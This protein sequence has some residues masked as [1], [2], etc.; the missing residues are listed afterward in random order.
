MSDGF[1]SK[2][3]QGAFKPEQVEELL[4]T[5]G[6]MLA[7]LIDAAGEV[8]Q[9]EQIERWLHVTVGPYRIR[10]F[11]SRGGMALVFRAERCDGQFEQTVAIKVLHTSDGA[12]LAKRFELERQMLGKLEHP[13]IAR[14]LDSGVAAG[15]PWLAMEFVDGTHIGAYCDN[16]QLD[17]DARLDLFIQVARA[18]Q[19]AHGRLIVHRDIKPSNILVCTDGIT[20]LLDF[21]IA[22]VLRGDESP[23]LTNAAMLLTPQYASPEQVLGE[24]V[25]VASDI[26]QLGLLL[27]QLLTGS[28]PQNIDNVSVAS[29]KSVVID[30]LPES[31]SERVETTGHH[32]SKRAHELAAARSTSISRLHKMLLG[33]LD[34]IVIKCL[35]K[36]PAE[37]YAT[38]QALSEDIAAFRELRPITARAP[39]TW[40]RS[41]RFVRRHRGGVLSAVLT[42]IVILFALAAVGVS[43]RSTIDAQQ[44]ALEEAAAARQV[45]DFLASMLEEANP[46]RTGGSA[47]TVRELLDEAMEQI[48]ALNDQPR[49]QARLLEV[50]AGAYFELTVFGPAEQ[51]AR[52]AIELREQIGDS[53]DMVEPLTKLALVRMELGDLDEALE[54]GQR[55][56]DLADAMDASPVMRANANDALSIVYFQRGAYAEQREHL[57]LA[58]KQ[59]EVAGADENKVLRAS[60][61]YKLAANSKQEGE[62]AQAMEEAKAALALL[63][64]APNE[65]ATRMFVLRMLG[66]AQSDMGDE[67]LA[68]E[69]LQESVDLA[70][71]IYREEE[72]SAMML[73][74]LVL[75]ARS[76]SNLN[77]ND[78]AEQLF[79]EALSIAESNI[80]RTHGNYAR[81]LHDYAEVLRRRGQF[82]ELREMRA[83][84]VAIAAA[85]FGPEHSTTI[86]LRKAEAYI[87]VGEGRYREALA[88]INEVL[89]QVMNEFGR[90]HMISFTTSENYA[91]ML[92]ETGHVAEARIAMNDLIGDGRAILDGK[93]YSYMINLENLSR[94]HF[95]TGRLDEARRV[96]DEAIALGRQL[97]GSLRS[98]VSEAMLTRTNVLSL[99]A[100]GLAADVVDPLLRTVRNSLLQMPV[101]RQ[102]RLTD[103]A[104]ALARG[105]RRAESAETCRLALGAL[106]NAVSDDI[107]ILAYARLNCAA[108]AMVLG[109]SDEAQKLLAVSLPIVSEALGEENWQ[110]Q[111]AIFMD[112]KLRGD[113][114][115]QNAAG[116]K[117]RDVLGAATPIFDGL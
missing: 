70:R 76:L 31:P 56:T 59:L 82:S 62:Y 17:I 13:G 75:L 81:I 80:G 86:N 77:R 91:R 67:E 6:G 92:L 21:G 64:D 33:D 61:L 27:Y 113:T 93:F 97:V 29:I 37:R 12:E 50:L 87:P 96:A 32:D 79:R 16:R 42:L 39:S 114:A 105:N 35:R 107:P 98:T 104:I 111:W 51:A 25:G 69:T 66:S 30:R 71:I 2:R 102:H 84:A 106:G 23:D 1:E 7:E 108:A 26:Y 34:I 4:E 22:K 115:R 19:F 48:E 10:E 74:N 85:Y 89:P 14:I 55:A 8:W 73:G 43:W 18:V 112:A 116:S 94:L 60:Y 15:Q 38:V 72:K 83:E 41:S 110:T 49:V 109:N 101:E 5:G 9:N 90:D 24:P 53:V 57:L 88:S 63:G 100:E 46:E 117:V 45:G 54:L 44:Q 11:I 28:N 68:V 36:D 3:R 95:L 52:R 58:L 65:R 20:K 40:Y 47:M 78:E 103:L 99:Q